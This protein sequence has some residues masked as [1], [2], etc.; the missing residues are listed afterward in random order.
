VARELPLPALL[1]HALVAFTI[2][3]DNEFEHQ[4]LA[5]TSRPPVF[6]TSLAM[7]SN[8]MRFVPPDGIPTDALAAAARVTP[9]HLK[10]RLNGLARWGYVSVSSDRLVRPTPNGRRAQAIWAP[11]PATIES[12]WRDRFGPAAIDPLRQQLG[13][14][15]EP[16]D[17]SLPWYLPII[18]AR[19][20]SEITAPTTPSDDIAPAPLFALLARALLGFTL[21]YEREV[22]LSLPMMA[23][24][25]RVL[26]RQPARLRDLPH[27]AGVSKEAIAMVVGFLGKAGI[28]AVA[29][30]PEAARGKVVQLT[31]KGTRARDGYARRQ[32]AVERSWRVSRGDDVID[33]LTATLRGIVG[34]PELARSPLAAGLVAP[35]GTWRASVRPPD[36]LPEQLMVL[37]RGGFPDGA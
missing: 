28:V 16:F 8:Y 25:V 3:F 31:E 18:G 17:P 10:S 21:E 7:W 30:D 1:S 22:K 26:D 19:M 27:R 34:G 15:S 35:P 36:V 14:I 24:V 13:S 9:A 33:A 32:A 20:F 4:L 5:G 29:P 2:E 12:R 6:L 23:N 37:H 11:L